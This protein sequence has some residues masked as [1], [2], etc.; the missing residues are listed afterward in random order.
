[1]GRAFAVL[2]FLAG[3]M[4]GAA[5]CGGGDEPPL[6]E[7]PTQPSPS[8]SLYTLTPAPRPPK[9]PPSGRLFA[10]IEQS[11]RDGAAGR[12]QVWIANDTDHPVTPTR[13]RYRDARFRT[14]LPAAR[15]REIPAGGRSGFP[16]TIPARPACKGSGSGTLIADYVANGR[17]QRVTLP[18]EDEADVVERVWASRCL[19]L[20]V[21]AIARLSWADEVVASGDGGKG[22]VGTLTLVIE[23]TGR[24]GSELV[25]DTITGNPVLSPGERGVAPVGVLVTGDQSTQR[26]AVPIKPARCDAHAFADSGGF[27]A[28]TLNVHLDGEP[29]QVV[30]R[31]SARGAANALNYAKA[32]CGTLT[33]ITGGEG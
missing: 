3:L 11:S 32:S 20:E 27:A 15:L 2:V 29:G 19:E 26:L 7:Q 4:T 21:A 12:F 10:A 24:P 1:M 31:L 23:P 16:I 6:P 14:S 9:P 17:H 25:I 18:V 13:L 8:R 22:S 5:A 28:F 33:T 30:L